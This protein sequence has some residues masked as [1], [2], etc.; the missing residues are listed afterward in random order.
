MDLKCC[1]ES[2]HLNISASPFLLSAFVCF[3]HSFFQDYIAEV[4][5]FSIYSLYS[6]K[7]SR[8]ARRCSLHFKDF[9]IKGI[10]TFSP[11]LLLLCFCGQIQCTS[12]F[13]F[14]VL[15]FPHSICCFWSMNFAHVPFLSVFWIHSEQGTFWCSC[16]ISLM[17]QVIWFVKG[18]SCG[19]LVH[20]SCNCSCVLMTS[21]TT[22]ETC[23]DFFLVPLWSSS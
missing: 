2:K 11:E 18:K 23:I 4:Y 7:N 13:F 12:F 15:R 1:A 16:S 10:S 20:L 6:Y 9:T 3:I 17:F 8:R 14:L 19:F 5:R 21:L 22:Q